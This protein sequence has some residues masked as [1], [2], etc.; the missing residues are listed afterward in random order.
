MDRCCRCIIFLGIFLA[1]FLAFIPMKWTLSLSVLR[2]SAEPRACS[3]VAMKC[4]H[5]LVLHNKAMDDLV[6]L[7]LSSASSISSSSLPP[8]NFPFH[9]FLFSSSFTPRLSRTHHIER[10]MTSTSPTPDIS[11]LS[12]SGQPAQRQ[13]DP[14]DYDGFSGAQRQQFHFSTNPVAPGQLPYNPLGG[15]NT[16]P[17]KN[18]SSRAGLPTVCTT[19]VSASLYPPNARG[20]L[21]FYFQSRVFGR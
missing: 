6:P 4:L 10:I 21:I 3:G 1:V 5:V 14:Y 2:L 19:L 15:L 9:F 18:K 16:S 13:H 8:I 20:I 12:I 7:C 17:L 11:Q